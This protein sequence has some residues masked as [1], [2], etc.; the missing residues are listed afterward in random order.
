MNP[1]AVMSPWHGHWIWPH[2]DD[3]DK[4]AAARVQEI[5]LENH[6]TTLANEYARQGKDWKTELKQIRKEREYLKRMGL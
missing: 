5:A 4:E 6:T 2:T 1:A 3:F